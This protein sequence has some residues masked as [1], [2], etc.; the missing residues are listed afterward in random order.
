VDIIVLI[1]GL[2]QLLTIN[3][4][5]IKAASD[6]FDMCDIVRDRLTYFDREQWKYIME[7]NGGI[8][9]GCICK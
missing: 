8:F 4:S 5:N 1:D 2:Y 3:I 6:C 9:F 7:N